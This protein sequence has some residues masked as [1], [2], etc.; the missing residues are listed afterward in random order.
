MRIYCF[1]HVA[2]TSSHVGLVPIPSNQNPAVDYTE[3]AAIGVDKVFLTASTTGFKFLEGKLQSCRLSP[4]S[5]VKIHSVS[6]AVMRTWYSRQ[7][8]IPPTDQRTY[9]WERMQEHAH[10]LG[11]RVVASAGDHAQSTVHVEAE[12]ELLHMG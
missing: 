1:P 12:M 8:P 9:L 6:A 11:D 4:S 3:H 5:C 10:D 2:K 7:S